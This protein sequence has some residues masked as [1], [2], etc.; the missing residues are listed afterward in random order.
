MWH[1]LPKKL[2]LAYPVSQQFNFYELMN[3]YQ[4]ARPSIVIFKNQW[5]VMINLNIHQKEINEITNDIINNTRL[6]GY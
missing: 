3:V 1:N 4:T 6:H 2:N 5:K